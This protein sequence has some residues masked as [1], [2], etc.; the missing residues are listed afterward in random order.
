MTGFEPQMSGS[1]SDRSANWGTT[2]A[3]QYT[4]GYHFGRPQIIEK[5]KSTQSSRF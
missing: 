2:T 4:F 1:G 3:P 5:I